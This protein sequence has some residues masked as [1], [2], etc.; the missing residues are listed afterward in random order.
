MMRDPQIERARDKVMQ[1]PCN[2]GNRPN[3][4]YITIQAMIEAGLTDKAIMERFPKL[5]GQT[6]E[7][8]RHLD[9]GLRRKRNIDNFLDA[10][11]RRR[12]EKGRKR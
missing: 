11:F 6:M 8:Y 7:V 5:D 10:M 3:C 4:R 12:L 9:R 2:R 1:L